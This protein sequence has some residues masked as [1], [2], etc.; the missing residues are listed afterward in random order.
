[1]EGNLIVFIII[2]T[3]SDKEFLTFFFKRLRINKTGHY[4]QDFPYISRC[5][6]EI[7]FIKCESQPI[8]YTDII[9][10]ELGND[11]IV[12]NGIGESFTFPFDPSKLFMFPKD[13]RVYH[14]TSK[15]AGGNGILKTSL[16]I[17]LAPYFVFTNSGI[18][19]DQPTQFQWKGQIYDLD[20]IAD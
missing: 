8:V 14:P 10:G 18:D 11:R 16:A 7:N 12:V 19:V 13:G 5:G 17:E 4:T 6:P 15:R 20:N 1:M 3:V 2:I 9:A